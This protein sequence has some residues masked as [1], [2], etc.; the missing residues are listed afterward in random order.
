MKCRNHNEN[1]RQMSVYMQNICFRLHFAETII[2]FIDRNCLLQLP[3]VRFEKKE[4]FSSLLFKM[5]RQRVRAIE[6]F[7]LFVRV[8]YRIQMQQ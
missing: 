3:F 7:F 5:Y 2:G 1:L 6:F 4:F 8:K